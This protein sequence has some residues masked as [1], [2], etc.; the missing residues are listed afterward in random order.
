MCVGSCRAVPRTRSD[1]SQSPTSWAGVCFHRRSDGLN[2]RLIHGGS[3]TSH[4]DSIFFDERKDLKLP[5]T[6][7]MDPD[8]R[9]S[10]A[11]VNRWVPPVLPTIGQN[12]KS[13]VVILNTQ[14]DL[15]EIVCASRASG[16]FAYLLHCWKKQA[17]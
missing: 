16:G 4:P 9:F 5:S 12:S 1:Q 15:F 3:A 14:A 10:D 13:I 7:L 17:N 8:I 2:D 11:G 6:S